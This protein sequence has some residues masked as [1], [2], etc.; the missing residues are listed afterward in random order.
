MASTKLEINVN[1]NP[2]KTLGVSAPAPLHGP[3][4]SDPSDAATL[5]ADTAVALPAD[6]ESGKPAAKIRVL[7][8]DDHALFR[9]GLLE[10]LQQE[11]DLEIVGEAA[12]GALA[13]EQAQRCRPQVVL[14][15]LTMP[16][17]DGLEATRRITA[18]LPG[19]RVIGLSAHQE[20]D[21]AQALYQAGAV[22]YLSK[23]KPVECLIAA[24]HDVT[25]RFRIP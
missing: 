18:A 5:L 13:V 10:V 23:D 4:S 25:A 19:V 22:C 11:S 17:L 24:I 14:M 2:D 7:V 20:E 8:A 6:D 16:N 9:R 3:S 1:I 15:D 21:M 12:D